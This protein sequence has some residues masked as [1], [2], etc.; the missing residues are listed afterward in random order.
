MRGTTFAAQS[1]D[2]S[3]SLR[4]LLP[5]PGGYALGNPRQPKQLGDLKRVVTLDVEERMRLGD[6]DG[7]I[8]ASLRLA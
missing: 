2:T 7:N 6:T 8:S 3:P 4:P 5:G 1:S